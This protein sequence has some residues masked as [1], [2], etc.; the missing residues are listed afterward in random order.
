VIMASS[1]GSIGRWSRD[2][3]TQTLAAAVAML[4]IGLSLWV[5][6][7]AR[8]ASRELTSR[9]AVWQQ[10]SNQLA[11][12]QQQFRVP[13]SMESAALISESSRMGALGVS[14]ADQLT[15]IESIGS[16]AEACGLAR[17]RVNSAPV[18]DTLFAPPRSIGS[19]N[20]KPASY[21]VTLE[22]TGSF[23]GLV[24]FVSSL[25]PSVSV[26]RIGAGRGSGS[27]AYHLVLSVYELDA[28]SS[29]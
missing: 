16:L 1:T 24:Q 14:P 15:L 11:T 9:K 20:L 2:N 4:V 8:R 6:I 22:F 7:Q 12:V 5:G 17:V 27:T 18:T 23:A 19:Q 21:A 26:S 3:P 13:S 28:N 10:A 29:G 25:P